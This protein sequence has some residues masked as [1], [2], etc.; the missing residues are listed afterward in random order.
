MR[1]HAD[2][3][4]RT[5]AGPP[6]R[7]VLDRLSLELPGPGVHAVLGANGSGKTTLLRL[8][9]L[10]DAPDAGELRFDGERV[11]GPGGVSR[12]ARRRATLVFDRPTLLRGTVRWNV[13]FALRA[14][15][16]P[17]AGRAARLEPWIEP[18]GLERILDARVD[19]ISAGEARRAALARGLALDTE[20][21]LLDEPTANL[22]PLSAGLVERA[23]A[24]LGARRETTVV[25][26][27][28]DLAQA[29][30]LAGQVHFLAEGRIAQGGEAAG[31][32]DAPRSVAL[33]EFL[34]VENLFRGT[35][36]DRGDHQRFVAP[37]IDWAVIAERTGACWA[38]LPAR[39]VLVARERPAS[40]A[41]NAAAG[42]IDRIEERGPMVLVELTT[43]A[44][45]DAGPS[46]RLSAAV[47][48]ATVQTM[49]LAPGQ[50][51][52]LAW[53]AASVRLFD[54]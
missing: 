24:G 2:G 7:R 50:P 8:L 48:R 44:E 52:W 6:P 39:D 17:T 9:A 4:G 22:D 27:T 54:G 36:E 28:H 46:V 30:R 5:F 13:E 33:A 35:V 45:G 20:L 26:A 12:A 10:L 11:A 14:R 3:L 31:V 16:V 41:M 37:G 15:G 29:R 40:S 51:A 1:V 25:L 21:L 34:G 38:G 53:K 42:T 43:A 19:R 23:I 32:L 49:G 18:L 47:T